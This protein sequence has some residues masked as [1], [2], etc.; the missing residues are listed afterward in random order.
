M[1]P[2]LEDV[3]KVCHKKYPGQRKDKLDN[4]LMIRLPSN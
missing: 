4:Y 1:G 2:I 3:M